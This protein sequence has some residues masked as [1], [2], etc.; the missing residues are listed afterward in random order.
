MLDYNNSEEEKKHKRGT[1]YL[2]STP[3][4]N[5]DDITFR[6]VK[7]MRGCDLVICEE[8]KIGARIL[9]QYNVTQKMDLLNEQNEGEKTQE[10]ISMLFKGNDLA[11]ISDCGT[12]VF[13]DPGLEL[14][15]AAISNGIPVSVIPGPSSIMTAVVRSGF[16]I[17]RFLY[18][19]FLSRDKDERLEE[20]NELQYEKG[21]I[22]LLETPYRLVPV[23]EAAAK[24]MPDRR[25][26][27]GCNLTMHFETHHYGTFKELYYKFKDLRFKGEFVLVFEG[28]GGGKKQFK[29]G[30]RKGGFKPRI[31]NYKKQGD[32][33]NRQ[34]DRPDRRG[35]RPN[36]QSDRPDRRGDRPNKQGDFKKKQGN[37]RPPKTEDK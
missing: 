9:H 7:I 19:G 37:E 23:L 22:V 29:K 4:G 10:Y 33:P 16:P 26:Y 11:L 18:A 6:A 21:T 15:Q 24:I 20:L 31:K 2:V 34:G 13:A 3:I 30:N 36:R 32:R 28:S 12:P 25:V 8:A 5:K 14:V 17:D 27:L 35:D 1:L